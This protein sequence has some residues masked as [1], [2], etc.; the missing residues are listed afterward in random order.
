MHPDVSSAVKPAT[1][2]VKRL[3]RCGCQ[4]ASPGLSRNKAVPS[5]NSVIP[6]FT[7]GFWPRNKDT[8]ISPA[9]FFYSLSLLMT[10][11]HI[12]KGKPID[13]SKNSILSLRQW[14]IQRYDEDQKIPSAPDRI[15]S[16]CH[17]DGYLRA[18][19]HILEMEHQ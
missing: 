5:R 10:H 9:P 6:P 13:V 16:C 15:T 2:R 19:D 14:A 18:I 3:V 7:L 11:V 1:A 8:A 12:D 4:P 17:W